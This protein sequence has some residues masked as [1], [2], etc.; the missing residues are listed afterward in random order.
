MKEQ[1]SSTAL[2]PAAT[3]QEG[4]KTATTRVWTPLE[5]RAFLKLPGILK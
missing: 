5:S 2:R 3:E 1:E 4:V